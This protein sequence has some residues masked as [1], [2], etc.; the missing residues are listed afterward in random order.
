MTTDVLV[1]ARAYRESIP[2]LLDRIDQ[3]VSGARSFVSDAGSGVVGGLFKGAIALPFDLVKG[4]SSLLDP[5][6]FSAKRLTSTDIEL[7]RST[8]SALLPTE[9]GSF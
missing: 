8:V 6:S 3:Q 2:V 4:V 1:E 9:E 7:I 5:D